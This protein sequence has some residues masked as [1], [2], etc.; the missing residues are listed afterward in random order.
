MREASGCRESVPVYQGPGW[1]GNRWRDLECW[2]GSDGYR[3][4]VADVGVF[5]VAADGGAIFHM[6]ADADL[7][8]PLLVE[9]VLGPPLMLA[10][11][12]QGTWCL[13]ASAVLAGEHLI[14]FMGESGSGKSTLAAFLGAGG[15]G[16]WRRVADDIV[17]VVP[18][19]EGLEALPRFPQLKLPADQQPAIGLPE[20]LPLAAIYLLD[21]PKAGQTDVAIQ[22]LA[23]RQGMLSLIRHTVAARLFDRDL[24]ERHMNFC[25]DGVDKVPVRW[26]SFPRQF[27]LLPRVY[28]ALAADLK[29]LYLV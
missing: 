22:P 3:V 7:A 26:L 13:H 16:P 9:T 17:P 20:R 19:P 23:A 24:L 18:R 14:A 6:D 12:L 15:N 2:S 29:T 25:A 11:A 4:A 27:G 8:H 5:A 28:D 10:L 21:E 1:I